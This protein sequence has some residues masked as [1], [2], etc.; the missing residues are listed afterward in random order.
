MMDYQ[1]MNEDKN[2]NSISSLSSLEERLKAVIEKE[3]SA[4]LEE[5]ITLLI[6]DVLQGDRGEIKLPSPDTLNNL[7]KK[8]NDTLEDLFEDDMYKDTDIP[9]REFLK[10]NPNFLVH[11]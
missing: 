6:R 3:V 5:Y 1:T 2:N 10:R 4:H 11:P 9:D 8:V 7:D